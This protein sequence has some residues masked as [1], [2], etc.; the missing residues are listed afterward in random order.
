MIGGKRSIKE[1]Q[2][3]KN[4]MKCPVYK[5]AGSKIRCD[6]DKSSEECVCWLKNV[7]RNLLYTIDAANTLLEGSII[8]N[9]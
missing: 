5:A 4:C 3:S 1:K 6:G 9:E 7:T 2:M 8:E